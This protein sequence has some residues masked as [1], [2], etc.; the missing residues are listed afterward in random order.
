[1]I[2]AVPLDLEERFSL[3]YG[4]SRAVGLYQVDPSGA[5]V[6]KTWR[7]EPVQKEPCG[8]AGWLAALG[9]RVILAGGMGAGAQKQFVACGIDVVTGAPEME[10]GALV[11]AWLLG[12]LSPGVN[13]CEGGHHGHGAHG[14]HHDHAHGEGCGCGH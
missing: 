1:M 11:K 3:H 6:L 10:P 4:A 8:W 9:V 14:H 12:E 2:V 5:A 13:A 7:E